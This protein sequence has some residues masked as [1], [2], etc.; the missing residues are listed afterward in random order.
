MVPREH[1]LFLDTKTVHCYV[2]LFFL[3]MEAIQG[4]FFED[5]SFFHVSQPQSSGETRDRKKTAQ[6]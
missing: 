1:L 2:C 6:L 3:C 4:N 5:R